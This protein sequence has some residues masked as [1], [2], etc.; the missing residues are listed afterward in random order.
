[1]P[2]TTH[3]RHQLM[4]SNKIFGV[5]SPYIVSIIIIM[6]DNNTVGQLCLLFIIIAP[7]IL[8]EINDKLTVKYNIDIVYVSI[9]Y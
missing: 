5:Q 2:H 3:T 6:R 9:T 1:M 7:V 4:N 8:C